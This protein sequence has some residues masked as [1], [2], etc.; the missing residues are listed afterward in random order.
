M[1][2]PQAF[3]AA[4]AY[5]PPATLPAPIMKI[6]RNLDDTNTTDLAQ[7]LDQYNDAAKRLL[8]LMPEGW[9]VWAAGPGLYLGPERGDGHRLPPSV[10][11]SILAFLDKHRL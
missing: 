9:R 8:P 2:N 6:Y 10:I 7:W 5:H 4:P 3:R 1:N 11:K